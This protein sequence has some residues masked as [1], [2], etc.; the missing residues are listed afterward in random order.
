MTNYVPVESSNL[1]EVGYEDSELFVKF[2]NNTEYKYSGVP[3]HVKEELLN[4]PSI[5]QY[6]N[7]NIKNS[8][9]FEKIV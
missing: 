4:A 9:P 2:K 3:L 1:S 8:Y 6:F 5:G 7:A